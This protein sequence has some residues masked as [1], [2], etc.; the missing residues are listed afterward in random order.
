MNLTVQGTKYEVPSRNTSYEIRS[1]IFLLMSNTVRWLKNE[2][3]EIRETYESRMAT[4]KVSFLVSR[5]LPLEAS[6]FLILATC[7]LLNVEW[8]T[9]SAE[10]WS[11][12][13]DWN[14]DSPP[15]RSWYLVLSTSYSLLGTSYRI[16]W[17]LILATWYFFKSLPSLIFL[18][19]KK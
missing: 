2:E 13:S 7:Y 11:R 9:P 14:L 19:K 5:L 6:C 16:Y 18:P 4:I 3:V 12:D 10:Y 8:W 1:T 17:Y 15:K